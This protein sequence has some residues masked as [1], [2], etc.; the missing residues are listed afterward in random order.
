MEESVKTKN[1]LTPRQWHLYNFLKLKYE[2]DPNAYVSKTEICNGLPLDYEADEKATRFCRTIEQDINVLRNSEQI[3]K[4]IVS[5]HTGYKIAT[6]EEAGAW[7]TRIRNE[8]ILKLKMYRKNRKI[9]EA[10]NQMR[11][12]F[13]KEKDTIEV[14]NG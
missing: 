12:V 8:A 6:K 7:L 13:N 2:L 1:E 10:N 14:F 3:Y 11:L 5:N 4:I 9:A